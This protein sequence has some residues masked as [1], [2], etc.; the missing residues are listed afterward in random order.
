MTIAFEIMYTHLA[1]NLVV[2]AMTQF[3]F[4]MVNVKDRELA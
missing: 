1:R 2:E 4:K 3:R